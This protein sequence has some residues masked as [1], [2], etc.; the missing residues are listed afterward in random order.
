MRCIKRIF[1]GEVFRTACDSR[2]IDSGRTRK[3]KKKKRKKEI[4]RGEKKEGK[5][6][7]NN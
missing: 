7:A 1:G 2:G 4:E 5:A 3:K 6:R